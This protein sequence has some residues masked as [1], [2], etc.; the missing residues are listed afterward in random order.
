MAIK[1]FPPFFVSALMWCTFNAIV[2]GAWQDEK[3]STK[4]HETD[5]QFRKDGV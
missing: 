2:E 4:N 5:L 3:K 1:S